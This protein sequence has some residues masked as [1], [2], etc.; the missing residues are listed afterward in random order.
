[1]KT[2]V[3]FPNGLGVGFDIGWFYD[4]AVQPYALV[5]GNSETREIATKMLL[6]EFQLVSILSSERV[7]KPIW[8]GSS[9][10]LMP[11]EEI[12]QRIVLD[13]ED[14]PVYDDTEGYFEGDGF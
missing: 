9:V 2:A 11:K 12:S 13:E 8:R 5:W 1:M 10:Y 4:D 14:V 3:I 6:N 7:W